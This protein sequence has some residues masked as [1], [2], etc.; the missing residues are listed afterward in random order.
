M[1]CKK[2]PREDP[3]PLPPK[4]KTQIPPAKK[5]AWYLDTDSIETGEFEYVKVRQ[6]SE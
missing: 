6:D 5:Y 2:T 1:K 4:Q 3:P